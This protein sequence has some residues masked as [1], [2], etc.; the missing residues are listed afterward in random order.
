MQVPPYEKSARSKICVLEEKDKTEKWFNVFWKWSENVKQKHALW[1]FCP[2]SLRES[3]YICAGTFLSGH[4]HLVHL[5]GCLLFAFL[6]VCLL[7]LWK[8]TAL[9]FVSTT[10]CLHLR[11]ARVPT[12]AAAS[13]LPVFNPLEG[14]PVFSLP[15]TAFLDRVFN[16]EWHSFRNSSLLK[17]RV[18]HGCRGKPLRVQ[19]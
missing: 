3:I 9:G 17:R 1:K 15:P 10:C 5:F 16:I 19:N 2:A 14:E 6:L 4:H 7:A 18:C 13:E 11:P 12:A 8:T